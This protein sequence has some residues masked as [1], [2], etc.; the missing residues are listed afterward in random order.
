MEN[1][2]ARD[3]QIFQDALTSLEGFI[4]VREPYLQRGE[5]GN[6]YTDEV[7][8]TFESELEIDELTQETLNDVVETLRHYRTTIDQLMVSLAEAVSAL[9]D[10]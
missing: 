7:L 10:A 8:C 4:K 2:D 9:E 1:T 3:V 5:E 6:T